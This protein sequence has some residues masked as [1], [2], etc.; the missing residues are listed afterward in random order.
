MHS[1]EVASGVTHNRGLFSLQR[2]EQVQNKLDCKAQQPVSS[3]GRGPAALKEAVRKQ[4][5]DALL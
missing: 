1:K 2:A 3:S 5:Q 4:L